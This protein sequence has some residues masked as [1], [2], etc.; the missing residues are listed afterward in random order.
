MEAS[1]SVTTRSVMLHR[2]LPREVG[3]SRP[4]INPTWLK[5][6]MWVAGDV[7][8]QVR[9]AYELADHLNG[10]RIDLGVDKGLGAISTL[11][12]VT[13]SLGIYEN[14]AKLD[15]AQRDGD[16][17]RTALSAINIGRYSGS[18]VAG[19]S[20]I[21]SRG[22]GIAM[23]QTGRKTFATATKVLG[24][25]GSSAGV[26]TY[27]MLMTNSAIQ[28]GHKIARMVGLSRAIS[29]GRKVGSTPQERRANGIL[30]GLNYLR[31]QITLS[32]ADRKSA[33]NLA[34]KAPFNRED[35]QRYGQVELLEQDAQFLHSN[36][37]EVD[38]DS[39]KRLKTQLGRKYTVK[40]N[41]FA[42]Q[43]SASKF[44][45]VKEIALNQGCLEEIRNGDGKAIA[46]A[47]NLLDEVQG[48]M[49]NS[50][51]MRAGVVAI[52]AL[53]VAAMI[54]SLIITGGTGALVMLILSQIV[55]LGMFCYDTSDLI[56][57]FKN[58]SPGRH[59]HLVIYLSTLLLAV[60]F[61]LSALLTSGI[62][63]TILVAACAA[64][65]VAIQVSVLLK[66]HLEK[67]KPFQPRERS[68]QIPRAFLD[69][70]DLN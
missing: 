51:L 65:G 62:V 29:T 59:D 49:K 17:R 43:I 52:C 63:P 11:S 42:D 70:S 20:I 12:L 4:T 36:G 67:N 13:G 1:N 58:E 21:A 39:Y 6:G 23:A 32:D 68:D 24:T 38:S 61:T 8:G 26:L 41:T 53:G 69:P 10:H 22:M 25:V 46:A 19:S 31:D 35:F 66:T 60:T 27:A 3:Q 15:E 14:K 28:M 2:E 30:S 44:A 56:D 50:V 47:E 34:K 5:P 40:Q 45:N 16:V 64:I 18:L 54:G 57:A 33:K 48:E 37:G 9:N 55:G 7:I